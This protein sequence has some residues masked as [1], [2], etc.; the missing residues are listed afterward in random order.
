MQQGEES[1]ETPAQVLVQTAAA[2]ESVD[3]PEE[4]AG[5][6]VDGEEERGGEEEEQ[7]GHRFGH[8]KFPPDVYGSNPFNKTRENKQHVVWNDVKCLKKHTAH[9]TTVDA[10]YTHVCT[11]KITAKKAGEEGDDE[12]D[13]GKWRWY[14]NKILKLKKGKTCY[15][16]TVA[17]DSHTLG[18]AI[19]YT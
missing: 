19:K 13:D 17:T 11:A 12:D 7:V 3:G 5:G 4:D 2:S 16:T 18:G 6:E 1:A 14:C 15:N 8:A 9:G 10:K